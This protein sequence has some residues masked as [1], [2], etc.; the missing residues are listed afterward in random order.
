MSVV[1]ALLR[2]L[3]SLSAVCLALGC[4]SAKPKET[5]QVRPVKTMVVTAGNK[6]DVRSF[7]GKVEAAKSVSLA[8]QVPGLLIKEPGK[9]GE[10]VAKGDVSAQLRQ[11]EFQ[12]RVKAAQGQLDQAQANLTA[13]KAGERSEEQLRREAQLRAAEAKVENTK[14]EFDRYARLLPSNAVS[15]SDYDLAQTNYRVAQE[16][17]Q[18]ARQIA[19]KGAMARKE[20]IEAQEAVVSGLEAKLSEATVQFRDSTLRAPYNGIIA[21]RLVNEGQPIAPNTP[22]VKFQDDDEIDIVMDVP[23]KFM[24][25]E[26]RQAASLSMAAKFSGAPDLEFPVEMKEAAQAADP[27]TQTFQV[28]VAMKRPAGFTA[29]PG[30]TAVVKVV[31]S[32]G[33]VP[34]SRILV[35][36][37]AVTKTETETQVVWVVE[38]NQTVSPR[39][40]ELGAAS[41]GDIEILNGLQPGDRVVVAG[42]WSLRPGMKVSDLGDVLGGNQV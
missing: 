35:P 31:Y 34:T 8:F 5:E 25:N 27:K 24:A 12:A 19:E 37:S 30:M 10:R 40:V 15:K 2:L 28:R 18:S 38:P 11:D 21:Q 29:L 22:V 3:L 17:E 20:D 32:P 26:I 42:A 13:L 6:P 9:E 14:V 39:P 1:K 41:G 23:E 33:G 16:E 7:P 36:I 4:S